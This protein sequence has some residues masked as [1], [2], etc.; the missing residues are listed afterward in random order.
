M[1]RL[2]AGCSCC[3]RGAGTPRTHGSYD[4]V[5]FYCLGSPEGRATQQLRSFRVV[6]CGTVCLRGGAG[7]GA[8][9]ED[10]GAGGRGGGLVAG[11]DG[12]GG[13]SGRRWGTGGA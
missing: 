11:K 12:G 6:T 1:E 8:A 5:G 3:A 7:R 9:G 13:G 4:R 10:G 2:R